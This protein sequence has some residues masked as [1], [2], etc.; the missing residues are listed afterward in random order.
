MQE[1]TDEHPDG[2]SDEDQ[3]QDSKYCNNE[4]KASSQIAL[5][6]YTK[7][8]ALKVQVMIRFCILLPFF[9]CFPDLRIYCKVGEVDVQE[10]DHATEINIYG[11]Y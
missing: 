8:E 7:A 10:H 9:L 6:V 2:K 11:G 3:K 5:W 4:F 1:Y